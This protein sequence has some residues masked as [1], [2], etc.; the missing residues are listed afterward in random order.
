[1]TLDELD[2]IRKRLE[3]MSGTE[4]MRTELDEVAKALDRYPAIIRPW[5]EFWM[6]RS[7]P[8]LS[9]LPMPFVLT[10]VN[11]ANVTRVV[12]ILQSEDLVQ[13]EMHL[14]GQEIL[15]GAGNGSNGG[16]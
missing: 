2:R 8:E 15:D 4:R 7:F 11:S 10:N 9:E 6:S 5:G 3:S 14:M 12:S 16:E 13:W 1:M